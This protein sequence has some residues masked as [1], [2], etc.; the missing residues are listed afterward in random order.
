MPADAAPRYL[1]VGPAWVGDMVMAQSLF[2]SLRQQYPKARIDVLAPAWSLP[3]VARMPEVHKGISLAAGHGQFGLGERYRLGRILRAKHYDRAIV[4][5]RSFKSAL[6]PFFAR[7]PVR[8]GYRGEMRYGL[9]NDMRPLD[10]AVL[11]QTVQRQ[12]ALGQPAGTPLP[13]AIPFP[14]LRIDA[15]NQ[16]ALLDRLGLDCTRPVVALLPGAEYGPAKQWPLAHWRQLARQLEDAGRTVWVLGSDRDRAVGEQIVKALGH[17][18]NL[19]GQ[20]RLEDAVDLLALCQQAVS[21]DSGL[22][23]MAC[24]TGIPVTALYGSSS[25]RYTPPLSDAA[26]VLWLEL[27]CS[28]CFKRECPQGHTRCLKDISTET[29]LQATLPDEKA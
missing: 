27:D 4:I 14:R 18:R 7:I 23:H 12:V 16:Q 1:I 3:L 5:P 21:N 26:T 15:A 17:G 20:T 8:T 10:K 13:P 28:P 2:I 9:L 19:A 6:V 24:A 29:V 11:S 22:M 25:P